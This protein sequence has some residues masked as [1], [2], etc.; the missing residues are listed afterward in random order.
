MRTHLLIAGFVAA[1][2]VGCG[3]PST[4]AQSS[5]AAKTVHEGAQAV[6]D[7]AQEM[8]KA[9]KSGSEQMASGV[10]Q[11]AHGLEQMAQG[12]TKAVDYESLKALLPEMDGWTRTDP[13]GEQVSMPVS[14][15]RA[16]AHYRKDNSEIELEISDTALSQLL[17]APVSM[18][19]QSGY[20]E[21]SDDGFTRAATIANQPG[22]EEWNAASH[23]A[24]VTAVAG[25]R[26]IVRA[27]GDN[28][29]S[30]DPVR[31]LVESVDMTKLV[32]LK[33]TK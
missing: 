12:S 27:T 25:G 2:A 23:H 10:A 15:S 22:F 26:F 9:A 3:Q 18:F 33:Q 20:S 5:D 16:E 11:M 4:P 28:V 1:A 21:R 29:A 17:L 32:A 30:V 24:E 8:A 7:G 13:K 31:Q 6:Q 19:L 14:H